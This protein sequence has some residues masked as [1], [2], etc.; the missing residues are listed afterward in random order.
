MAVFSEMIC[1]Q[2]IGELGLE[3]RVWL[4][5]RAKVGDESRQNRLKLTKRTTTCVV[6]K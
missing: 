3:K 1:R 4:K 6:S 5:A 2:S